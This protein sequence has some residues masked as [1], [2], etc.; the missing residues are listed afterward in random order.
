MSTPDEVEYYLRRERQERSLAKSARDPAASA[1][2]LTLAES[3]SRLVGTIDREFSLKLEVYAQG[4]A[5]VRPTQRTWSG[6]PSTA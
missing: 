3:Y 1:I 4:K 2:H 5:V 6:V